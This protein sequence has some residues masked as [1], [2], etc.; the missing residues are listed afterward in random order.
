VPAESAESLL[1]ALE[2]SLAEAREFPAGLT[3][4]S[5]GEPEAR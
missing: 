3:E 2:D 5:A 4:E 1:R